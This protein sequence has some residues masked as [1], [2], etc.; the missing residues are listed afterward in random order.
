MAQ[1]RYLGTLAMV[2]L[3][4]GSSSAA[5]ILVLATATSP[6][7]AENESVPRTTNLSANETAKLWSLDGDDYDE[8]EVA[9][10]SGA[11]ALLH[12]TD[13]TWTKPPQT[14]NAWT[15]TDFRQFAAN[16][17]TDRN[18]SI[19]P[20]HADRR[21][22]DLAAGGIED[23]HAS[24]VGVTPATRAYVNEST[25]KTYLGTDGRVLGLVDYRI[26]TPTDETDESDGKTVNW[27]LESHEISRVCVLQGVADPPADCTRAGIRIAS[28]DGTHT[29]NLSYDALE[30]AGRDTS[31]TLVAELEAQFKKTVRTQETWTEEVCREV[32]TP[33]GT[34]TTCEEERRTRWTTTVDHPT[35]RVT[36]TDS[37]PGVTF[38]QLQTA[39]QY[40]RFPSG[41]MG[42]VQSSHRWAGLNVSDGGRVTTPWR[43]YAARNTQWD[44]LETTTAD[45]TTPR[46]SP[47][48]PAR[49][50]A[51]PADTAPRGL[52]DETAESLVVETVLRGEQYATPA[53][54]LPEAVNVD[55][56]A[57]PYTTT[58][59]IA[60]RYSE[61]APAVDVSG[62]VPSASGSQ[63]NV[64]ASNG[65]VDVR[66]TTVSATVVDS[67]YS[68]ATV[69]ATLRDA[70]TGQPIDLRGR[71]GYVTVQDHRVNTNASGVV[72]VTV[73]KRGTVTVRYQPTDWWDDSP[74]YA[75]SRTRVYTQSGFFS[76]NRQAR[77]WTRIVTYLVPFAFA[78]YVLDKLP[79]TN[80]W[81]PWR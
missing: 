9:N 22:D 46:E 49:T 2:A 23:A 42:V 26:E 57:D 43:F 37:L 69:R 45:E 79:G 40:A 24:L 1:S 32:E 34:K 13:Y 58:T 63:L 59:A 52:T 51:F 14:P 20:S 74:A 16:F 71:D 72:L 28:G 50:Y 25:T 73:P 36:V 30:F 62:L 17:S 18:S 11:V 61:F 33:N 55:V 80:A 78:L 65:V 75:S 56:V 6:H 29:P 5:N 4:V 76:V 66:R 67:N 81:P 35:S 54:A 10:R 70:E 77:L 7:V 38:Y 27:T 47:L 8:T 68:H 15:R 64:S 12:G 39:V 19:H 21:D 41:D 48:R 3:V 60:F 44:Q 53:E 31:V